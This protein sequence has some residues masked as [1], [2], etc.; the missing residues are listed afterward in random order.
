MLSVQAM[1]KVRNILLSRIALS[2]KG[3]RSSWKCVFR[4]S[5]FA[6]ECHVKL[7]SV[8]QLRVRCSSDLDSD[9]AQEPYLGPKILSL[10]THALDRQ[11][12][13][14]I[15]LMANP[16]APIPPYYLHMLC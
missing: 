10:P 15:A 3:L 8:P 13:A 7:G 11:P 12:P 16:L 2:T 14:P 1:N 9:S 5:K 4:W 6:L